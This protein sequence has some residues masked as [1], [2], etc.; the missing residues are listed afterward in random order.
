MRTCDAVCLFL[1]GTHSQ[2][3]LASFVMPIRP[4]FPCETLAAVLV[5]ISCVRLSIRACNAP[6]SGRRPPA[7]LRGDCVGMG[8]GF[9]CLCWLRD[10]HLGMTRPTHTH[11]G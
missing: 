9:S 5:W 2:A 10:P 3:M 8:L 6:L 11:S 4:K 7:S 1:M